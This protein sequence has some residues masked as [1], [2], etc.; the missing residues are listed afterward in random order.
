MATAVHIPSQDPNGPLNESPVGYVSPLPQKASHTPSNS[1]TH[2]QRLTLTEFDLRDDRYPTLNSSRSPTSPPVHSK[3]GGFDPAIDAGMTV[4]LRASYEKTRSPGISPPQKSWLGENITQEPVQGWDPSHASTPAPVLE[5]QALGAEEPTSQA[6]VPA[7]VEG[8]FPEQSPA[9]DGLNEPSVIPSRVSAEQRRPSPEMGQ[10]SS[11]VRP[12]VDQQFDVAASNSP[13]HANNPLPPG[14]AGPSTPLLSPAAPRY[15]SLPTAGV[16]AGPGPSSPSMSPIVPLSA[17]PTYNPSSMQIPISPKPRAY[18]QHPTYITPSPAAP[19]MQPSFS[20]PQVPKEEV[21][22]EC[23]MRDQDMADVDVT[24]PGVWDR[25]S[26][27]FYEE[28]CKRE[29]EEEISGRASS[30]NHSRPRAKGG[31]LTEENLRFWL[32]IVRFISSLHGVLYLLRAPCRTPRSRHPA[33]RPS[34]SM[35]SRN[36]V[37]SRQTPCPVHARCVN[38]ACSMRRC[39]TRF[40]SCVVLPMSSATAHTRRTIPALCASSRPVSHLCLLR[41]VPRRATHARSRSSRMA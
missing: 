36:A 32:S 11:S 5:A 23:A 31:K 12:S 13:R 25:E 41:L 4:A 8:Y 38:P 19:A 1:F 39:A 30:E 9:N 6:S 21:C 33:S 34:T 14:A 28:L 18:A 3:S 20:P 7:P 22:V 15:P 35:S 29:A 17:G 37:S 24:S 2:P 16:G 27:V 26:D 40:R 10:R